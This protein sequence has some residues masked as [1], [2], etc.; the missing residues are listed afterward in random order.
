[1]R[2]A[3]FILLL[4]FTLAV[5]AAALAGS[6]A[7]GDGT[8][9]VRD[10]NGRVTLTARGTFFGRVDGGRIVYTTLDPADE[11][12]PDFFDTCERTKPLLDGSVVCSGTSLRF[13]LLGASKVKI[14]LVGKGIDLSAVGKGQAILN[15]DETQFDLGEYALNGGLYKPLPTEPLV[16]TF[17]IPATPP[18]GP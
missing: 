11:S 3:S 17:G 4:V 16:V 13:R 7:K 6:R 5:P 2:K 14:T 9:S 12:F 8:L 10:G 18:A 1:M 15:G